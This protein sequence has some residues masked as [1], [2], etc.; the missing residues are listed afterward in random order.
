MEPFTIKELLEHI[1]SFVPRN[2]II[3]CALV[4]KSFYNGIKIDTDQESVAKNAD[5][6][7][8]LKIP[9]CPTIVI[10]F[11]AQNNNVVMFEYLLAKHEIDINNSKLCRSIG[12]SGNEYLINKHKNNI[13]TIGLNG[14]NDLIHTEKKHYLYKQIKFGICEG[15]HEN[16]FDK[17]SIY[18]DCKCQVILYKTDID[19]K[20]LHQYIN[21]HNIDLI[22]ELRYVEIEGY[23]SRKKSDEVKLFIQNLINAGDIVEAID[24]V[25]DGLIDG[26]H[27]ELFIW[28]NKN[29]EY[30][31]DSNK[32]IEKLIIK[33][34]FNMFIHIL[35]NNCHTPF[36][37]KKIRYVGS[38]WFESYG[39]DFY[40]LALDCI[41]YRRIEM[42]KF[43]LAHITFN[44]N[45]FNDFIKNAEL[46]KFD[47]IRE[48]LILNKNLFEDYD[49]HTEF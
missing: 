36:L 12:Q 33:N 30:S 49:D 22:N 18:T 1:I 37:N 31:C 34:N 21:D 43:L 5:M 38:Y 17:Y 20:K 47:D 41:N 3:N 26:N 27:L 39:I 9:Y 25:F 35:L 29:Y 42:L 6:F 11:A 2:I 44:N 48:L 7:S 4:S 10:N 32:S 23:C 15:L 46:F 24:Y 40:S 14:I 16:L 8:L 28:L 13:E 45:R 19:K